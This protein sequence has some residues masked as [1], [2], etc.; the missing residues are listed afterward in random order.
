MTFAQNSLIREMTFRTNFFLDCLSSISWALMNV[1]FY[2]LIFHLANSIGNATGWVFTSSLSFLNDMI[3]NSTFTA[4]LMP[5][6]EEFSELIRREGSIL[7]C[8]KPIDTQFLVSFRK[9]NWS[10]LSKLF[11]GLMVLGYGVWNLASRSD[12]VWT[13][14]WYVIPL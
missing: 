6:A 9:I 8:V 12:P 10:A 14:S 3:I 13:L 2:L 7:Q 11:I 4:F 5:N 1:G